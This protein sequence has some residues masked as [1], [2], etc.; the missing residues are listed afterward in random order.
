MMFMRSATKES[1]VASP[2]LLTPAL[3]TEELSL[4]ELNP[5]FNAV[6][7]HTPGSVEAFKSVTLS[8]IDRFGGLR[9]D[10]L[11]AMVVSSDDP[12]KPAAYRFIARFEVNNLTEQKIRYLEELVRYTY[13]PD[14]RTR[15][16]S[17]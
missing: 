15:K 4:S 1:K 10:V 12:L 6:E 13:G 16:N 3:K 5:L 17:D 7:L 9:P 2:S 14:S 8:L 11:K